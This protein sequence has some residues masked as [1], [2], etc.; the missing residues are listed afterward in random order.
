MSAVK[1]TSA[2]ELGTCVGLSA[3]YQATALPTG[4]TR[5]FVT[6]EGAPELAATAASNL[7]HLGIDWARVVPG[8]FDDTVPGLAAELAPLHYAFIDGHHD[9]AATVRYFD[10]LRPHA[11]CRIGVRVRRH[12]L[13]RRHDPGM[14]DDRRL[15]T[16]A[17]SADLGRLGLVVLGPRP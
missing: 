16:V 8:R 15:T 9:E 12:P 11:A 5:T 17:A 10:V 13:V 4:A 1:P 14:G 3:A 6:C 7:H 2:I